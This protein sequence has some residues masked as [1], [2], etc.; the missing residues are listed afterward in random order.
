MG[1]NLYTK[2]D[3]PNA[4]LKAVSAKRKAWGLS[5]G[6]SRSYTKLNGFRPMDNPLSLVYESFRPENQPFTSVFLTCLVGTIKD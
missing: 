2:A 6:F 5:N 3:T 1:Q 4:S